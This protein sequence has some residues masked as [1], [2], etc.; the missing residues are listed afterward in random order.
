MRQ[1]R[2][3]IGLALGVAI[4]LMLRDAPVEAHTQQCADVPA[5]VQ[6]QSDLA[7]CQ[8][9]RADLNRFRNAVYDLRA[10]DAPEWSLWLRVWRFRLNGAPEDAVV[11]QAIKDACTSYVS[12]GLLPTG[13]CTAHGLKHVL[14][15]RLRAEDAE[16]IN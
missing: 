13:A 6:C 12:L 5:C 7:T 3:A 4:G 15:D 10:G 11:R 14:H 1:L 2:F 16:E 9:Q 8:S